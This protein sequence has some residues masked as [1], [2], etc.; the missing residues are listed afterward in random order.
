MGGDEHLDT[1]QACADADR[2][3]Q[4]AR[5]IDEETKR[6]LRPQWRTSSSNIA[7]DFLQFGYGDQLGIANIAIISI[8]LLFVL[9]LITWKMVEAHINWAI[10]N[11][12]LGSINQ[13]RVKNGR[14]VSPHG[15]RLPIIG[16]RHRPR[17]IS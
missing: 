2:I 9:N 1:P 15:P 12:D 5:L 11:F 7:G 14:H 10:V 3:V 4:I 8:V 17:Q 6:L 13:Q 16:S